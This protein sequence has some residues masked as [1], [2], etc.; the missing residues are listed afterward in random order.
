VAELVEVYLI[1]ET[2]VNLKLVFHYE[3]DADIS[4]EKKLLG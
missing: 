1:Q 4:K 3:P 2:S